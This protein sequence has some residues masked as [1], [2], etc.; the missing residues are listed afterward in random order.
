M[1][2][3]KF[4]ELSL[5]WLVLEVLVS[6]GFSGDAILILLGISP[7]EVMENGGQFQGIVFAVFNLACVVSHQRNALV[8]RATCTEMNI[9]SD[10]LLPSA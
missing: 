8:Y 7:I 3:S 2:H 5:S 4:P 6:A 10:I 9:S 1:L